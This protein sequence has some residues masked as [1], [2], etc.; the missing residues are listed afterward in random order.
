MMKVQFQWRGDAGESH[1]MSSHQSRPTHSHFSK[2][3]LTKSLNSS[4]MPNGLRGDC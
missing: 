2:F 3:N 1:L 4:N